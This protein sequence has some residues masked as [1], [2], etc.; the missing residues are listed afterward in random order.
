MTDVI[1]LY[2]NPP[3]QALVLCVD[4]KSQIQA[5]DRDPT[6]LA[7]QKGPLWDMTHDYKRNG[8][9]IY[10]LLWRSSGEGDR[11]MLSAPS[12][13]GVLKFLRTQDKEFPG[14]VPL[15]LA[16]T[17]T[18]PISTRMCGIG[19]NVILASCSTSSDEFQLAELGRTLVRAFG[20]QGDPA[21]RL[22]QRGG[23]KTSIDAFLTAWN[24]DPKPFVWTATVDPSKETLSLPAD[25]GE[26]PARV[27]PV[28]GSGKRK[29]SCPSI[30]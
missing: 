28:R 8:T 22:P 29:N 21:G 14:Q 15:H 2:L 20:R 25:F 5:L 1:G 4:E 26:D 12:P 3:E 17:T 13:S 10:S 7:A 6:R 16:W 19:S 30:S 24:K 11:P 9:T 23:S 18:E 27:A